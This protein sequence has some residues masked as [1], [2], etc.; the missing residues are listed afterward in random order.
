MGAPWFLELRGC[1]LSISCDLS[2]YFSAIVR[3]SR[4]I[5]TGKAHPTLLDL[6]QVSRNAHPPH[7][8]ECVVSL[9]KKRRQREVCKSFQEPFQAGAQQ[10]KLKLASPKSHHPTPDTMFLCG[11]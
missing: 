1:L 3:H 5:G 6:Q 10:A 11:A 2:L 7:E 9:E 4:T 8:L